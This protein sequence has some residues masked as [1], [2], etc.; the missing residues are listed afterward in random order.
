MYA[1]LG[2]IVGGLLIISLYEDLRLAFGT[3]FVGAANTIYGA[4]ARTGAWNVS[5]LS[6]FTCAPTSRGASAAAKPKK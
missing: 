6:S 3:N 5:P 4:G 1:M 2:P